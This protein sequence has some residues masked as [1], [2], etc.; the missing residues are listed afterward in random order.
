MVPSSAK[1]VM[2]N[3]CN[4]RRHKWLMKN[5]NRGQTANVHLLTPIHVC[6][7]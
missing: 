5:V 7:F 4:Q 3:V 6:M 2:K 1:F